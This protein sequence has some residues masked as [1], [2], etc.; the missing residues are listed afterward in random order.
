MLISIDASGKSFRVA[1][2]DN[3]IKPHIAKLTEA[4][5]SDNYEKDLEH[6]I[7]LIKSFDYEDIDAIGLS[8]AGI[9]SSDRS[10]IKFY[11]RRRHWE[12]KPIVED[13]RKYFNCNVFMENNTVASALGEI[14]YGVG[15]EQDFV[16]IMWDNGIGASSAKVRDDTIFIDPV[17][18]A[19]Q[20]LDPKDQKYPNTHPGFLQMYCA[21]AWSQD[22]YGKEFDQLNENDWAELT[23]KFAWGIVNLLCIRKSDLLIFGG[24]TAFQYEDRVVDIFRKVRE[25]FKIYDISE[26]RLTNLKDKA[27]LYG[28]IS[29]FINHGHYYV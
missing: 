11:S 8:S 13:L 21:P 18:F 20:I 27:G 6:I 24:R 22:I 19:H 4:E 14:Q 5:F 7:A 1:L 25:L 17:E 16:F 2:V 15:R 23:D 26:F 3:I 10:V 9:M 12:N 28:G 29:M